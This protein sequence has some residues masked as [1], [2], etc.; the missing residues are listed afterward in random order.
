MI[1]RDFTLRERLPTN[2]FKIEIFNI[3]STISSR[4]DRMKMKKEG[5]KV[6]QIVDVP[7]ISNDQYR[8]AHEWA[9]DEKIK[10]VI[11]S[12]NNADYRRF[13]TPTP[14]FIEPTTA[15]ITE[16][17][18]KSFDTFE[19]YQQ[20]GHKMIYQTKI[21]LNDCFVNSTCTCGDFISKFMCKHIIG[22][23]LQLK[24]KACPKEGNSKPIASKRKSA[25]RTS[26]AKKALIRQI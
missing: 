23:S 1:K 24:L 22:F 16:L 3:V 21:C 10:I 26:R 17:H 25:G 19:D 8:E 9:C 5:R 13:L 12:E 7:I 20:N 4:Y 11:R 14:K 6:K 18:T 15:K 2:E